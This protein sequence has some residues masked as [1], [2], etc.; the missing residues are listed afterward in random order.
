MAHKIFCFL[1]FVF[2]VTH[3]LSGQNSFI[4]EP[5]L[6]NVTD[7]SFHVLC[8]TSEQ[9]TV[10]AFLA[11]AEHNTLR[12]NLKQV[13]QDGKKELFHNVAFNGLKKGE[14]YVYRVAAISDRDTL[15]GP[16][17]RYTV[18]D[19]HRQPI[20]CTIIGDTQNNPGMWAHFSKMI[21]QERPVF[22]L[23]VGDMIQSGPNKDDWTDE[24][25]YPARDLFRFYPLYPIL[26]NHEGNSAFYYQYFDL[27]GTK[28]FYT[29]KKGNTL[30][31]FVNTNMDILPGSKQYQML[32]K[33]L[34][35]SDEQWKIVLHHH[36]VYVSSGYYNL[37]DQKVITG[38][39][40]TTQ[41]RPLYET[42]GVD[43][44]F[45]GHIHNYERTMPIYQGQIDTEKGVTYITTGGGGGKLDETAISRTWFMAETK[46]RHHYIKMKIW[47][48]TLSV[49]A[50][51]S[52]GVEFDRWEKVKDRVWLS[53]PLIECNAFSFM[54]QT[55]VVVKNPNPNSDLVVQVNGTYQIIPS[56]E[57]QLTLDETT[58]LTAFVKNSAGIE[59]RPVTRTFSK[60]L[61]MPAQKKAGK[62]KIKAEYY[63]GFYT[64]LPDFDK[65]K[66]LKTFEADTLSLDVI[67]PRAENHW[68]ARFHGRFTVPETKV[69][70][71]LLESYDGS[72]L[73]I[74]GKEIINNDGMHYE[75]RMDN[76]VALEKGEH[77]FEVQYFDFTRRETLR[78]WMNP[79]YSGLIEFNEYIR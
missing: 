61:L 30:F 73:L 15:W 6:Q 57:I 16:V 13:Q 27:P 50:I 56:E 48:N 67:K 78:L 23:H 72:R 10:I 74:D 37:I 44:V 36:P 47:D 40:N 71:I 46:S 58:I 19:F 64:V 20:V 70:R 33:T 26:G 38:D 7:T 41:L 14:Q 43:L 49:Q 2:S 11:V 75:I 55:K 21:A 3:Q 24:F 5:Y 65:Q 9:S 25:F 31:I 63:E 68:A 52:A 8:E 51:D 35:S 60:L 18:P 45:N 69:Y 66:P 29:Q 62:T 53:A 4:V 12:A 76:Y 22:L 54:E 28:W 79:M 77:T 1:I 59:S 32:E 17:S 39:P 42:Y 34:A